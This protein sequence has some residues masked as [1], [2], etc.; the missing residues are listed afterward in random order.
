MNLSKAC[1]MA[2][3]SMCG[4]TDN[5]PP[6][7]GPRRDKYSHLRRDASVMACRAL[8]SSS[9]DRGGA[10]LPSVLIGA[11]GT[12]LVSPALRATLAIARDRPKLSG[13]LAGCGALVPV[14]N[15][16]Q[17][18][19]SSGKRRAFLTAIAIM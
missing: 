8:T 5:D 1:L 12:P 13:E 11:L 2:M 18:S 17:Q 7:K 3:G 4:G 10:L 6:S 15:I 9:K 16:L 19:L 14:G